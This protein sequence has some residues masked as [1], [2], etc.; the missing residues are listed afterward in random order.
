MQTSEDAFIGGGDT[1]RIGRFAVTE[2]INNEP[3][4]MVAQ[5]LLVSKD[6]TAVPADILKLSQEAL[7][8]FA[9]RIIK[10]EFWSDVEWNLQSIDLEKVFEEFLES[11]AVA[12]KSAR[13][14]TSAAPYEELVRKSIHASFHTYDPFPTLVKLTREKDIETEVGKKHDSYLQKFSKELMIAILGENPIPVLLHPKPKKLLQETLKLVKKIFIEFQQEIGIEWIKK[15]IE[16]FLE[17][18]AEKFLEPYSLTDLR[19]AKEDLTLALESI[20]LKKFGVRCP[21]L[22]LLYP[23]FNKSHSLVKEAINIV[24][25]AIL[26]DYDQGNA[27][28]TIVSQIV[29]LPSK[30]REFYGIFVRS[31]CNRHPRGLNDYG[32]IFLR[33]LLEQ[34]LTRGESQPKVSVLYDF[35]KKSELNV[36]DPR[37][38]EQ[39]LEKIKEARLKPK[40]KLKFDVHHGSEIRTFYSALRGAIVDTVDI[41]ANSAFW[42]DEGMGYIPIQLIDLLE[43]LG[44]QI[45]ITRMVLGILERIDKHSWKGF[46]PKGNLASLNQRIGER[47]DVTLDTVIDIWQDPYTIIQQSCV[48]HENRIDM[49]VESINK[50][51][52]QLIKEDQKWAKII[53]TANLMEFI[54]KLNSKFKSLFNSLDKKQLSSLS[55]VQQKLQK[56]SEKTLETL[57]KQINKLQDTKDSKYE[58]TRKKIQQSSLKEIKNH[59]EFCQRLE[60]DAIKLSEKIKQ[61]IKADRKNLPK[62]LQELVKKVKTLPFISQWDKKEE[63]RKF[64]DKERVVNSVSLRI[65]QTQLDRLVGLSEVSKARAFCIFEELAPSIADLAM[66]IAISDPQGSQIVQNATNLVVSKGQRFLTEIYKQVEDY[67]KNLLRLI[68]SQPL[69]EITQIYL[70]EDMPVHK[71]QEQPC[72]LISD[73]PVY[74]LGS[75]QTMEDLLGFPVLHRP[76]PDK[77]GWAQILIPLEVHPPP[78]LQIQSLS[79]AIRETLISSFRRELSGIINFLHETGEMF[80]KYASENINKYFDEVTAALLF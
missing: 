30:E 37:L 18:E 23:N 20:L 10:T 66:F 69:S 77:Q 3:R 47:N 72:I 70:L 60:K 49:E 58:K 35:V 21:V 45:Y 78:E 57:S 28:E 26:Q 11:I 67:S 29:R 65:G 71:F 38:T 56:E 14:E 46:D 8:D 1:S 55:E 19:T 6:A 48:N 75:N 24:L 27:L 62:N 51:L 64:P 13:I 74:L 41:I 32:W 53:E 61:D 42:G 73:T 2:I 5:F 36:A 12:R 33:R 43:S 54:K 34:L 9:R 39:I 50:I 25:D 17:R 7:V 4:E 16:D 79:Q 31:F 22:F 40:Q 63:K 44:K 52:K 15:S 68:I 80:S 59:Q 76:S